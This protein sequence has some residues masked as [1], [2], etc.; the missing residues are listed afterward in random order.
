VAKTAGYHATRVLGIGGSGVVTLSQI[1]A[2]AATLSDHAVITLDQTGLAQKG[3][4]LRPAFAAGV[5]RSSPAVAG[6]RT[7]EGGFSRRPF[8]GT[9]TKSYE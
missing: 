6:Q 4:R 8:R 5:T 1:L 9:R 7:Q 3:G 2:A